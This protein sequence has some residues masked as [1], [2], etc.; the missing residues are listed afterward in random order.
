MADRTFWIFDSTL[1]V[2][3]ASDQPDRRMGGGWQRPD[4]ETYNRLRGAL[5]AGGFAF[6]SDPRID[7]HYSCL[8]K[9]HHVGARP[10]RHGE[11]RVATETYPTGCK[12]EF[13]QDVVIENLNGGLYDF[14]RRAKM[15]YLIRKA[16]EAAIR[17]AA[18]H[19]V[20]RGFVDTTKIDSP[21]PDPV[22]YFNQSWNSPSDWK[23]GTHRFDRGED[24]WPS[25]KEIGLACWTMGHPL[26]P[27]GAIRY[28]RDRKGRLMRGRCYGGINGRWMVVYGPG[29]RDFTHLSRHELF[30]CDPRQ[31][32]RRVH[33]VDPKRLAA[34]LAKAVAAQEF[35]RAIV[36]RDALKR[37]QPAER[38]DA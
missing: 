35:E 17:R 5:E 20:G 22:A 31:Q 23:R 4:W 18:A 29:R 8:A 13:Y 7:K 30:E 28:F 33:P 6:T 19:L 36:I 32:P 9:Y 25:D 16:W 27:H 15:P 1:C 3:A 21:N 38:L 2:A 10:T 12:F 26:I 11:L 34:V 14:D 37:L 24:G